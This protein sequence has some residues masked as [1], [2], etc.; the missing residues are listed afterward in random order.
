MGWCSSSIEADENKN[1]GVLPQHRSSSML[2]CS[3]TATTNTMLPPPCYHQH[4]CSSMFYHHQWHQH[5]T[6]N[7]NAVTCYTTT[8]RLYALC[9]EVRE[10]V[11]REH[12]THYIGST[13]FFVSTR[14]MY[15]YIMCVTIRHVLRVRTLH[16]IGVFCFAR[17]YISNSP[18]GRCF[19]LDQA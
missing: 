13:M 7:T 18:L 5:A 12:C 4:P 1:L 15:V 8:T 16:C 14:N 17:S 9:V 6:T 3:A 10:V 19:V 11:V 2:L